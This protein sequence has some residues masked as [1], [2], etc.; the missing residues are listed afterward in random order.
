MVVP[1]LKAWRAARPHVVRVAQSV[2]PQ[3]VRAVGAV[4]PPLVRAA[5]AVKPLVTRP[6][7][8]QFTAG[9]ATLGL[10]VAATVVTAAG[11]W[12]STGQRTAER[13]WAASQG[14]RRWRRS[15]PCAR[16]VRKGAGARS[17]AP[18]PCSPDSAAPSAPSVRGTTPTEKALADVLG[19]LLDDAALGS[20]RSAAVVDLAT[21]QRLY[22]KGADDA[23][24]P[25]STTKIATAVAAL[26][27]TGADHRIKTRTVLEPGTEEVVLVG[28]GDPTLTA[29][30]DAGGNA[31]LR[32]LADET[33]RAL[34]N[35]K[36]DR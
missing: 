20:E 7:T 25:A 29:R 33:A 10:V 22:G 1:E 5:G 19:P 4:K 30:K 24:T 31:S 28:G 27:A 35:R 21:G 3:L 8:V 9:S 15:R 36:A 26:A 6:S 2:R 23:L 32:T 16:Y 14:A 12:D 17:R 34:K 13:D 11:P 18:R